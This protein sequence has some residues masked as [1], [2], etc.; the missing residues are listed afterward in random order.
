M[1]GTSKV[2][3]NQASGKVSGK[4][5]EKHTPVKNDD[6]MDD[7]DDLTNANHNLEAANKTDNSSNPA[8]MNISLDD[9][10]FNKTDDEANSEDD[11]DVRMNLEEAEESTKAELGRKIFFFLCI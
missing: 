8:P 11:S 3:S 2:A 10:N 6:G 7:I 9:D 5:K 1:T 4:D